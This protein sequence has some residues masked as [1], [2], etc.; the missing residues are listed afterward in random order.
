MNQLSLRLF[1]PMLL[2]TVLLMLLAGPLRL[3]AQQ[4]YFEGSVFYEVEIS[5]AQAEAL[6]LNEPNNRMLMHVKDADYIIQLSG[7]R[8]PKTFMFVADSNYEYSIDLTN[9]R[10]FRYSS[11]ADLNR[12]E[13]APVK[14]VATGKEEVILGQTCQEYRVRKEGAEFLYY[15]S[16]AY[17]VN[18]A[19][20][21]PKTQA[22]AGFLAPGLDGRIPLRTIRKES[23][24]IV[25]TTARKVTPNA[26]DVEQFRIPADFE[27]KNRDYR[28]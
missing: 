27:V 16:D 28:Y 25:T 9:R 22:K 11:H 10:A 2:P 24:L 17:R 15:V 14:A 26:F 6:K 23:G 12:V 5:G 1:L 13:E 7:G 18:T 8:Y 21:P 4:T 19:L 20:Y 3:A